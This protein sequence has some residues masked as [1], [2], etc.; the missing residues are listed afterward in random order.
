MQEL[1]VLE[2][3][4]RLGWLLQEKVAKHQQPR[5]S[6]M[7]DDLFAQLVRRLQTPTP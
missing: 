7:A 2:Q 4:G 1:Q 3:R 6:G 5:H